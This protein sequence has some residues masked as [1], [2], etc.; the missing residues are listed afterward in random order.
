MGELEPCEKCGGYGVVE[1]TTPLVTC[2]SCKRT[3]D[4][5]Q[6]LGQHFRY[7]CKVRKAKCSH[8]W[9]YEKKAQ[10]CLHETKFGAPRYEI[11][12]KC[13]DKRLVPC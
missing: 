13:K 9:K 1:K 3:F 8:N 4:T 7:G 10:K 5:P 11:C 6:G 2:Q 12:T